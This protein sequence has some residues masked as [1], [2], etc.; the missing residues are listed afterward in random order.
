VELEFNT[1]LY[2]NEEFDCFD[3]YEPKIRLIFCAENFGL[4]LKEFKNEIISLEK[5]QN[6]REKK[7]IDIIK[8]NNNLE[9]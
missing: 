6:E 5:K 1:N 8:N 7:L 3:E 2:I 9:I 4:T